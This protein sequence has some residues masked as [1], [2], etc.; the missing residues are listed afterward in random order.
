[1]QTNEKKSIEHRDPVSATGSAAK[2]PALLKRR[3]LAKALSVS[4]RSIDNWQRQRRIPFIKISPR[5]VLFDLA[6]VLRAVKRFEVREV[7]R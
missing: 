6:S 4:A 3:E 1:M 2:D 7:G 5:C